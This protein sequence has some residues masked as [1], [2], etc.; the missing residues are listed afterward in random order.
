MC[1]LAA[2]PGEETGQEGETET[3]RGIFRDSD[4]AD[5]SEIYFSLFSTA[6]LL[7]IHRLK[8]KS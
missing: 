8:L 4:F 3:E 2:I 7:K 1:K 6:I 5:V